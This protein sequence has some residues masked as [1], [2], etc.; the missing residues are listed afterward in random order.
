M[1][2]IE[3]DW[4]SEFYD[5]EIQLRREL[6]RTPLGL[7]F[8]KAELEAEAS[9]LHFGILDQDRVIACAVVVPKSQ[10]HAKLRQ[11]AVAVV[12]QRAGVGT[13][14]IGQIEAALLER[15]FESIELSARDVAIGFYER[16]GYAKVG[17]EFIEVSIP[18]WK[19]TKLI[20]R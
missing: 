20:S 6:L 18:H 14:L 15:G 8:S 4:Q 10:T 12:H 13:K 5:Q 1:Q 17:D 9:E 19:M 16:L 7:T 11:M 2:F 3:I